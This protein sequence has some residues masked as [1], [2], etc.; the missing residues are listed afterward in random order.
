MPTWPSLPGETPIDI[1]GLIPKGVIT[2]AALNDLEAEN[3]RAATVRYL[4][5]KPSRRQAPFTLA[6]CLKLHEQMFGKVWRWAGTARTTELNLGVPVH[7]IRTD[8]QSLL[9][10]A[11]YWRDNEVFD[12]VEQ[13]SRLHHRVVYIHPFA[14][15]NGRW[16]RLLANIWLKRAGAPVIAWP[17]ETIGGESII[18]QAYLAAIRL[19]DD[20][21][22]GPLVELHR[23]YSAAPVK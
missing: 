7:R 16:S 9:D 6:W 14:N 22:Y 5:A 21:E 8:L 1:S 4:A 23:R 17:E 12:V 20:G 18:R 19:A 15:G 10:D 13:A 11:A 2:R 3:I